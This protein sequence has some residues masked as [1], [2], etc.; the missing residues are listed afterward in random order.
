MYFGHYQVEI[1]SEEKSYLKIYI[2]RQG[3]I[4]VCQ[5][6]CHL[7]EWKANFWSAFFGPQLGRTDAEFSLL[8]SIG[9]LGPYFIFSLKLILFKLN[10]FRLSYVIKLEFPKKLI[11]HG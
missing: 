3:K 7:F 6:P 1:Q 5:E 4:H 10:Q 9:L 8:N 11:G 2:K